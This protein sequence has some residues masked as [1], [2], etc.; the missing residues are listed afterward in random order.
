M[1]IIWS[2][3]V[4]FQGPQGPPGGIGNPGA[5]GEKVQ[6]W[7]NIF[8]SFVSKNRKTGLKYV[9]FVPQGE[10]GEAGPPGIVGEAG[11]KVNDVILMLFW[12]DASG[13]HAVAD[14]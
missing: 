10:P 8:Y 11:K 5:V 13:G 9:I 12:A 14:I 3:F 6:Y 2:V 1:E 4:C 7:R